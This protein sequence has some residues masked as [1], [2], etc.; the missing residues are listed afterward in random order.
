MPES[1][2][3]IARYIEEKNRKIFFSGIG[4][5]SMHALAAALKQKGHE[6]SGSEI[7][8]GDT[9]K[10]LRELGIEVFIGHKSENV[11]EDCEL[12]VYNARIKPDNPEM[13][14]A[15]E[16]NVLVSKRSELLGALMQGYKTSI[17]ISGTHGKTTVTSMTSEI[18]M[19]AKTA[20]TFFIG[21]KYPP[22]D[23]AYKIGKDDYFILEADEFSDSFLDFCPN[24]AVVLNIEMDHPDFFSDLGHMICSYE[25]FLANTSDCAI[26]NADDENALVAAKNFKGELATFSLKDP[27]ADIF[28]SN[29]DYSSGFPEFDITA[30]KSH[31]AHIRL[32]VPGEYN[33]YNAAAAASAA[34]KCKIEGKYIEAGL[35]AFG[36]AGRRF[37]FKGELNGACVYDDYAHHPTEVKKA[38]T[39]AIK[40]ARKKGGRLWYVFQPHT[41]SRTAELFEALCEA[42]SL[43]DNLILTEIFSATEENAYNIS[44]KDISARVQNSVFIKDFG[45]IAALLKKSAKENDLVLVT[46][47]G[48]IN[49]LTKMLV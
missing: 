47:A 46:G 14:E 31:Y 43:A 19:Q 20:P 23:S 8:A 1:A 48:D 6:I 41:Y 16:Q 35:N 28:V 38:I 11:D 29:I 49:N 2:N 7:V 10:K 39:E 36:G 33:I 4:G 12:F 44:S 22:I 42:L 13:I 24:V 9:V 27:S 40:L 45:E 3:N 18:F 32:R 5:I 17:G 30:N 15:K 21:A 37:E 26:I 25:K 34:Y